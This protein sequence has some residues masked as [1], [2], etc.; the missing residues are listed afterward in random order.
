MVVNPRTVFMF[1][2][3]GS[4]YFQMGRELFDQEPVFRNRMLRSDQIVRELSG[5]SV[6]E[7]LY[8]AGQGKADLFARTALTHPAIFMVELSLAE[9]LMQQDVVPDIV[10]GSSL[11]SFAAAT[12]AAFIDAEDALTAVMRQ[13]TTL[14][15]CCEEG[16]MIAVL[17]DPAVYAEDFLSKHSDLAAIN[18]SSHFVI[19][20]KHTE[21]AE[22]EANLKRRNLTFQRL[23]V[24]IAFHS[25]WMDPA[26][27]PFETFMKSIRCNTGVLPMMC[28]ERAVTLSALPGGYFWSAV[29][30]PIRFRDAIA[31]LELQGACRYI[32]VGPAGTLATFL[33]Y[34]LPADS[35][36]TLHSVLTPFGQDR[37]NLAS[38][39]GSGS[40]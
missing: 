30:N 39:L 11:G 9:L 18:F 20:A 33:K 12:V 23:P 10:L 4:H 2:G 21:L 38:L 5:E 16:G 13:A 37:K 7:T 40:R 1:S 3:Q 24:S 31:E 28:C 32:D 26:R 27:L 6:I 29:R 36:S 15:A 35:K 14:E 17:A 22:I 34:V 25:R 8:L 19:S